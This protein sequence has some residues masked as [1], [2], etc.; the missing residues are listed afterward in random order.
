[1]ISN[2]YIKMAPQLL[3]KNLSLLESKTATSQLILLTSQKLT[4]QILFQIGT[5]AVN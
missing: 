2:R 1:M 3:L 4:L 5:S